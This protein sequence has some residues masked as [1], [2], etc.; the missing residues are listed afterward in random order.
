[1]TTPTLDLTEI[2]KVSHF[3]AELRSL[4]SRFGFRLPVVS[5]ALG[6]PVG[7]YRLERQDDNTLSLFLRVGDQPVAL[8]LAD[9]APTPR[10]PR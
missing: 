10:S 9:E 3:A 2:R 5:L 1:M 8:V 4:E 7:D 6:G